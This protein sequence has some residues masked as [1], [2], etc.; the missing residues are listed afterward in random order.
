MPIVFPG[1][2]WNNMLPPGR[3]SS[4]TPRNGGS[5][6]WKQINGATSQGAQ[7]IYVAMFDEIDEGTAVYKIAHDVP[8]GESKFVPL[9]PGLPSD[10]YLW[11]TGEA[12]RLLKSGAELP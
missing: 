1:F 2:S 12:A 7:M 10:Y 9:E 11:L 8:V 4:T 3:P 6:L 5:F